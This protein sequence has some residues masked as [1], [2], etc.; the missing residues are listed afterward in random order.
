MRACISEAGKLLC[1]IPDWAAAWQVP[2]PAPLPVALDG[3]WPHLLSRCAPSVH[4]TPLR[5]VTGQGGVEA[6]LLVGLGRCT[7]LRRTICVDELGS[8]A[9]RHKVLAGAVRLSRLQL[10]F[11]H[12]GCVCRH[13]S[14]SPA[15]CRPVPCGLTE[16]EA[17][18]D[19][20]QPH[21]RLLQA[22][23]CEHQACTGYWASSVCHKPQNLA[24]PAGMHLKM[25][26]SLILDLLMPLTQ[27]G[28][29][30]RVP[31]D[32][33]P[34]T[35]SH[36]GRHRAGAGGRSDRSRPA[37]ERAGNLHRGGSLRQGDTTM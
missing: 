28:C 36:P 3:C 37:Q 4:I 13:N 14:F 1:Q 29:R 6:I 27:P 19:C 25:P 12:A 26:A 35:H 21:D 31:G 33:G 16:F 30:S 20:F 32:Q 23:R 34:C 17:Q 24:G 5:L 9:P 7:H 11:R 2:H 15:C 18:Q 22:G 10:R 8:P